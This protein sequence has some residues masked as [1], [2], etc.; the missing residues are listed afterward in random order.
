[1]NLWNVDWLILITQNYASQLEEK[2]LIQNLTKS[3]K[4]LG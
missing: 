1:M 3:I 4:V 2:Q